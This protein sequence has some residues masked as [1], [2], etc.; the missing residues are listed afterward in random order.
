MFSQLL[1]KSV[2]IYAFILSPKSYSSSQLLLWC[3]FVLHSAS[4]I[5]SLNTAHTTTAIFFFSL[6]KMGSW[7]LH[8]LLKWCNWM[9]CETKLA[10]QLWSLHNLIMCCRNAASFLVKL[11]GN[12]WKSEVLC[13][14]KKPLM[15][16]LQ[17]K[18]QLPLNS[19]HEMFCACAVLSVQFNDFPCKQVSISS[20][21]WTNS[22]INFLLHGC[23]PLWIHWI[24]S[25]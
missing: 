3:S 9:A 19:S 23:I 16:H 18:K 6:T 25:A 8:P 5:P 10:C 13:Y 21:I 11:E 17:I 2:D 1:I 4:F 14:R 22:T 12:C 24:I 15:H 7:I 20:Y